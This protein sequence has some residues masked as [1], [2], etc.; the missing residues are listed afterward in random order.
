MISKHTSTNVAFGADIC[1]H[2]A[3]HLIDVH[4]PDDDF[5]YSHP[6]LSESADSAVKLL[7]E[8][9]KF[10]SEWLHFNWLVRGL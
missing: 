2:A 10:L 8:N 1:M 4:V 3:L 7:L 5:S 6:E 9:Y